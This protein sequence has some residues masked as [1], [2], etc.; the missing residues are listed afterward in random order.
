MDIITIITACFLGFLIVLAVIPPVLRVCKEKHLFDGFSSRKVHTKV[1]P[2]IGGVAIF[3]GFVLASIFITG[4]AFFPELKYIIASLILLVGIGVKDDLMDISA[5]KKLMVQIISFLILIIAANIRI[6]DL[7]GIFGIHE[8]PYFV[9][10]FLSLF[11]YIVI[12]NAFNLIDGIDGLSSGLAILASSILGAW[13]LI[14]GHLNYSIIAFAL[15]GSLSAFFLFNVFGNTNKLFM[16]DTGALVIGTIIAVLIIRFNEFNVAGNNVFSIKN[17]PTVS[18]AII[19]APLIDTLRVFVIRILQK[20]SPFSPDRNHI[21]HHL[22]ELYNNHHL[23][24]TITILLGNLLFVLFGFGLVK[25]GFNITIQLT[26]LVALGLYIGKI[27]SLLN[28]KQVTYYLK[29]S[30]MKSFREIMLL[31]F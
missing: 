20:R 3:I 28:K 23:K 29:P 21:H 6:T 4:D 1:I 8:I 25:T 30:V 12:V 2:N 18:F 24:A 17:A 7:D 9:S 5:T 26:L 11:I 13:F 27:P 22:L 15:V 19:I 16:G 14:S 31:L 10:L